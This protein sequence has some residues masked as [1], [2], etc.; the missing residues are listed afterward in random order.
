[1]LFTLAVPSEVEPKWGFW[2][3]REEVFQIL[4]K[5]EKILWSRMIVADVQ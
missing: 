4:C 3:E 2:D 5:S 1:M